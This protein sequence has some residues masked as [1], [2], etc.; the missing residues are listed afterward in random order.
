MQHSLEVRKAPEY[1]PFS[2]FS[3]FD[4]DFSKLLPPAEPGS[5]PIRVTRDG[6][7]PEIKSLINRLKTNKAGEKT[8]YL[9]IYTQN[10]WFSPINQGERFEE[11][12]RFIEQVQ[13]D[14]VC[15]QECIKEFSERLRKSDV[16]RQMYFISENSGNWYTVQILSKWPCRVT[17]IPYHPDT[18]IVRSLLI[19]STVINRVP[20]T[21]TTSHLESSDG[22]QGYSM[23][24]KQMEIAFSALK[25]HRNVM[26]MGDFNY[27]AV[28]GKEEASRDKSFVDLFDFGPESTLKFTFIPRED[29]LDRM[30]LRGEDW[31]P[32]SGY[33][34]VG[35][36]P[37]AKFEGM[38]IFEG[39]Q[40]R[41]FGH[42]FCNQI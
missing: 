40:V 14:F 22:Y 29:R 42:H 4:K 19:A 31:E 30:L 36:E 9:T 16:I 33:S 18:V 2:V 37:I 12:V 34:L 5:Y 17:K 24:C 26:M 3:L 28:K 21:I 25:D 11:I 13:P 23:R 8:P 15:L 39:A 10:I 27:D 41:S 32:T 1:C 38:F 20:I 6:K 35:S 7:E